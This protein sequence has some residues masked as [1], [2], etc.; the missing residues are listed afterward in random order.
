[1]SLEKAMRP[2]ILHA[3]FEEQPFDTARR[4]ARLDFGEQPFADP[5]R[6]PVDVD[7]HILEHREAPPFAFFPREHRDTDNVA[8]AVSRHQ[9]IALVPQ[10]GKVVPIKS[11]KIIG[12]A[13]A[14]RAQTG[15]N[16][17]VA[18]PITRAAKSAADIAT[19]TDL[20]HE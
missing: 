10:L 2:V 13:S 17:A 3:A 9:Q 14:V 11:G 15:L 16:L 18:D 20:S 5:E 19:A 12:P 6:P 7:R 4:H 1:M 8:N